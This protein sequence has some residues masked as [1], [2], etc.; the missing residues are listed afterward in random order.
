MPY[1]LSSQGSV[2][3]LQ[4][5]VPVMEDLER[6]I[7]D[8]RRLRDEVGPPVLVLFIPE[9]SSPPA[10]DVA[11]R[12][13]RRL[14]E[15]ARQRRSLHQVFAGAGF[16]VGFKRSVLTGMLLA[17]NKLAPASQR[18]SLTV[19][20]TFEEAAARLPPGDRADLLALAT[21]AQAA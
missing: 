9:G 17:A 14:P 7:E 16:S 10:A 1:L 18:I 12:M 19:H 5:G 20:G 4:W 2:A 15:L 8:V 21:V 11:N 6:V 3:L 13:V